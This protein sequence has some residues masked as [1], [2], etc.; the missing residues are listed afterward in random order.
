MDDRIISD[1]LSHYLHLYVSLFGDYRNI[2]DF[3]VN[4]LHELW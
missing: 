4:F 1:N 2:S 3:G